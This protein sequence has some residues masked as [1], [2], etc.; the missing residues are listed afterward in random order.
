MLALA[1]VLALTL[2]LALVLALTRHARCGGPCMA[3]G[4]D[5]GLPGEG[6]C[7]VRGSM[8]GAGVHA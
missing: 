4:S 6:A 1:L 2:T 7:M 8:H 5:E 3:W